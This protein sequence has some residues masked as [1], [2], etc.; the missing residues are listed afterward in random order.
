MP[1]QPQQMG[2]YRHETAGVAEHNSEHEHCLASV[3]GS[4]LILAATGMLLHQDG[5]LPSICLGSPSP[6]LVHAGT[7][8]R[9][10]AGTS[11]HQDGPLDAL[12][13]CTG[14]SPESL[15][16]QHSGFHCQVAGTVRAQEGSH[17]QP[18]LLPRQAKSLKA[19]GT[20]SHQAGSLVSVACPSRL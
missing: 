16:L 6:V 5:R 7:A 4:A 19:S 15:Q 9:C 10:A 13:P 18:L 17:E 3:Q 11:S 12:P 14:A 1:L 20:N 8:T 2:L